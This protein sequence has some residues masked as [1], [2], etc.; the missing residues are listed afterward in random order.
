VTAGLLHPDASLLDAATGDVLGGHA[1]RDR[2]EAVADSLAT[3]P[4][5]IVLART[6]LTIDAIVTYLGCLCARRPVALLDPAVGAATTADL[7]ARYEPGAVVGFG[8]GDVPPAVD[9]YDLTGDDALGAVLRRR[10]V[11]G[12][13]PHERLGL[14]LATSGSTGNPRLVRLSQ[15]AVVANAASIAE[16]LHLSP[17]EVATTSLPLFYSYGLSVLNSHLTVGARVVVTD[18][19][20]L[21]RD[22]WQAV[23]AHDVTSLAAVPY[24]YE[25]LKRLRFDPQRYPSIRTLTQAG[26]RLNPDLVTDFHQRMANVDGRMFVMYGQTEAT[27]RMSV[28]P[29]E[30][31]GDKLGSVGLAIPGGR[32]SIAAES[33][34]PADPGAIGEVVYTGPN[35]MMGYADEA[36]DLTRGDELGGIL[37][38]GDLGRLD[39]EGFLY[40]TGRLKR[41]GKVFGVRVNLDDVERMLRSSADVSGPAAAVSG[42]DRLIVFLEGAD[43]G[44]CDAVARELAERMLLHPTGFQV[45]SVTEMPLLSNGKVDYRTLESSR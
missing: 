35:V 41:I 30:R 14:L 10:D 28:L 45:R 25:M 24:Q 26:G 44:T 4:A 31:L 27:A 8:P 17:T 32:F 16:A 3:L 12:V 15:E 34:A 36:A 19:P 29:A 23:N 1:L 38:T 22:F 13:V 5:G 42:E 21:S 39:D 40:I 6:P 2:A 37:H 9:G 18:Q 20:L 7:I 11:T 43:S 33:G